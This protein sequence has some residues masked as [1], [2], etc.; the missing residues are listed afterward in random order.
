MVEKGTRWEVSSLQQKK[1]KRSVICEILGVQT[2]EIDKP[3][4]VRTMFLDVERSVIGNGFRH[5]INSF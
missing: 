5:F 2:E 4:S 1:E 3:L